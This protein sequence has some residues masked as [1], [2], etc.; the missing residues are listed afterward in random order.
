MKQQLRKVLEGQS[1]TKWTELEDMALQS[2]CQK[3]LKYLI[4]TKGQEEVDRR[5]NF[6]GIK[7]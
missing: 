1:Y 5:V 6:L 4:K 7:M 2:K 3:Q